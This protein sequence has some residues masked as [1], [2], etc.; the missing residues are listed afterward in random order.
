[1]LAVVV[2]EA[3]LLEELLQEVLVKQEAVMEALAPTARQLL[4]VQLLLIARQE[5]EVEDT[6]VTL[7]QADLVA[8]AD[9]EL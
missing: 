4:E 3:T 9:Q 8:L 2:V 1:M 6:V 7:L 5:A